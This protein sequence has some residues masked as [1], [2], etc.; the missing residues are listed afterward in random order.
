MLCPAQGR[1]C[2]GF[3]E[4]SGGFQLRM[5][6]AA[7]EPREDDAQSVGVPSAR[8]FWHASASSA[9]DPPASVETP[10]GQ[11]TCSCERVALSRCISGFVHRVK[12]A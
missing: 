4:I 2:C 7:W 6:R 8:W 1:S 10:L 12:A 5:A 9:A 11:P 3:S